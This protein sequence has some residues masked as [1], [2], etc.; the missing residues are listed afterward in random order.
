VEAFSYGKQ[1]TCAATR[2]GRAHG[3]AVWFDAEVCDGVSFST[4]PGSPET[5]YGHGFFPWLE[6]VEIEAGDMF[7]LDF[8]ADLVDDYYVWRW[9]TCVREGGLQ[10]R[11]KASFKQSSFFGVPLSPEGLRKRAANHR[12]DLNDDGE[13]DRTVLDLMA[14]GVELGEIART[15]VERFPGRFS[16]RAQA[17]TRVANLSQK[18]GR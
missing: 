15:L 12:P 6:P 9:N 2:S 1:L 14:Q 5:I 7:E 4:A 16:N 18:Y 8:H 13:V 11:A 10:G 17:L 3:L